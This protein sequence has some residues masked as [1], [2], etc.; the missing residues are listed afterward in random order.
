MRETYLLFF[1]ENPLAEVDQLLVLVHFIIL[2]IHPLIEGIGVQDP[3]GVDLKKRGR[4]MEND[5]KEQS[6][7][8]GTFVKISSERF[9]SAM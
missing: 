6:D 3:L 2:F 1:R 9:R 4:K 5:L 7:V 8:G